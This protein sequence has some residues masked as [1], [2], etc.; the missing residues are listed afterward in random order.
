MPF[1]KMQLLF[2]FCPAAV[3]FPHG[4]MRR[5]VVGR[6]GRQLT[7]QVAVI[8]VGAVD[9]ERLH[10]GLAE[11]LTQLLVMGMHRRIPLVVDLHA[12]ENP[13]IMIL[14]DALGHSLRGVLLSQRLEAHGTAVMGQFD[15]RVFVVG[16]EIHLIAHLAQDAG[17][18]SGRFAAQDGQINV[19]AHDVIPGGLSGFLGQIEVTRHSVGILFVYHRKPLLPAKFIRGVLQ[20]TVGLFAV[21]VPFAVHKGHR[22]DDEVAVA[23]VGVQVGGYQHLEAITPYPLGQFHSDGVTLL[24]R[25]FT[26][27]ETLVGVKGH[28]AAGLAELLFGQLHLLAGNLRDTVD[29]ADE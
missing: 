19:L 26:G 27:A 29:T 17:Q 22:V 23:A 11:V 5:A 2:N 15:S 14:L 21:V 4:R 7:Q 20:G 25:D 6:C 24:R 8:Q 28:R 3:I 16:I 13:H 1:Q 9:A 18:I 12:F 10:N